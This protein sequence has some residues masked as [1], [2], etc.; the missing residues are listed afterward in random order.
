MSKFQVT[1]SYSSAQIAR[2]E[3]NFVWGSHRLLVEMHDN[4]HWFWNAPEDYHGTTMNSLSL[5]RPTNYKNY[6]KNDEYKNWA[7]WTRVNVMPSSVVA[8]AGR[9][10]D[11]SDYN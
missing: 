9:S 5:K 1:F 10:Q 3:S 11:E 8:A 7:Q 2:N 6:M 4:Q